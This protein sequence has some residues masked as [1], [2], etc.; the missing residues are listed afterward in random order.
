[1]EILE[2]SG[3]KRSNKYKWFAK[4]NLLQTWFRHNMDIWFRPDNCYCNIDKCNIQITNIV[5][6]FHLAEIYT[7]NNS[8]VVLIE[9]SAQSWFGSD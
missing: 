1:M 7:Q 8:I 9:F 3:E 2:K 6:V 4:S 5:I